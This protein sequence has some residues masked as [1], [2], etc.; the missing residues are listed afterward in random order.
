MNLQATCKH[1]RIVAHDCAKSRL[2]YHKR[3]IKRTQHKIATQYFNPDSWPFYRALTWLFEGKFE[4]SKNFVSKNHVKKYGPQIC[5]IPGKIR[6]EH[7]DKI[8]R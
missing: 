5:R 7:I 1:L 3:I 4:F 8:Y 6:R 2:N